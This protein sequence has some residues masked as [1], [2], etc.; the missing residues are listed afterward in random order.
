[1]LLLHHTILYVSERILQ[2]EYKFL[3]WQLM[4]RLEKE[5]Y[6]AALT[7]NQQKYQHDFLGKWEYQ[8]AGK[9]ILLSN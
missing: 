4:I 6:N 2:R 8:L 9:K 1:M 5:N 3:S 7:E